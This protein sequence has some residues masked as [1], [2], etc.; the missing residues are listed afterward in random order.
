MKKWREDLFSSVFKSHKN[1]LHGERCRK[2][3]AQPDET[4]EER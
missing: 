4:K 1:N 2:K 3:K